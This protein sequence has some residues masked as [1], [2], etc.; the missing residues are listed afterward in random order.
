M[1]YLID[2]KWLLLL[3]LGSIVVFVSWVFWN[4]SK[5]VW[6]EKRRWVRKYSDSDGRYR[7]MR[8]AS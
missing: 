1:S 2:V 3:P 8:R 4:L 5:E 6:A 7:R